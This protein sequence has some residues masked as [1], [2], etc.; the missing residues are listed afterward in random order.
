MVTQ[1]RSDEKSMFNKL[2]DVKVNIN[3]KLKK[4]TKTNK[5]INSNCSP[6]F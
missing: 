5:I 6:N 4:M 2:Q 3:N 1:Y